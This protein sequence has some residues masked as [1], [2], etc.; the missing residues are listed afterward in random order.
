MR[1]I[2]YGVTTSRRV[3]KARGE[4]LDVHPPL[5]CL[6]IDGGV[7]LMYITVRIVLA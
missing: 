7:P 1:L 3:K 2:G 5:G 6:E 4:L